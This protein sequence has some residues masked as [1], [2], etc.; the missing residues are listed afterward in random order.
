MTRVVIDTSVLVSGVLKERGTPAAVLALVGAGEIIWYVSPAVIAEYKEVL[1]RSKFSFDPA[2]LHRV[3]RSL[4]HAAL[5][6]PTVTR[7]ESSHE[8][9]NRFYECAHAAQADYIVTGNRKHFTKDLPPTRIVNA[10]ELLALLGRD[11][12]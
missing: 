3:L 9:D 2:R 5:V 1:S 8:A 11:P 12:A 10:R 4:D 6:V 7:T